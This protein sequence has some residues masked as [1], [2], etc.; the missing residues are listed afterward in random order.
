MPLPAAANDD[1]GTTRVAEWLADP[2]DSIE[3]AAHAIESE[4]VQEGRFEHDAALSACILPMARDLLSRRSIG[5][6]SQVVGFLKLALRRVGRLFDAALDVSACRTVSPMRRC[7]QKGEQGAH[8]EEAATRSQ[9]RC[10]RRRRPKSRPPR[11]RRCRHRRSS[12]RA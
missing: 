10:G 1:D 12:T 11:R 7:G 8:D 4:A 2:I 6:T 9:A 3:D 5:A